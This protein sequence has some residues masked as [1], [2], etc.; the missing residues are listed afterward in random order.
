MADQDDDSSPYPWAR[1]LR[2]AAFAAAF[3]LGAYFLLQSFRGSAG[4]MGVAFLF[5]LPAAICGFLAYVFDPHGKRSRGQYM[6]IPLWVVLAVIAVSAIV[7]REGVICI[8]MLSPAW[9]V[10]GMAGAEMAY[11]AKR[12]AVNDTAYCSAIIALPLLAM[13]L[14]PLIPVPTSTFT[15][16][17]SAVLDASASEIW[18]LVR[19]IP[20]VKPR[21]GCWNLSQDV[22]GIPR[23]ISARLIGDGMGAQ[24]LAVWG[25]RIRFRETIVDWAQDRRI[26]W[27]FKFDDL[28]GWGMTDRHLL[29]DSPHFKVVSGGY[30]LQPLP[31][32]RTRV[33]LHTDYR[34]TTLVNGYAG[35]WGELFLGDLENNLLALIRQRAAAAHEKVRLNA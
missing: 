35:L 30:D 32:G 2:T 29:P 28:A 18:P 27:R 14:E 10:A 19:G 34:V 24:R 17:R 31:G 4:V 25:S 11:R 26:G 15:V 21:E 1:L 3:A 8:L 12:V 6:L 13:T 33:T 22:I 23:P 9:L 16:T 20:D 5:V 7:L